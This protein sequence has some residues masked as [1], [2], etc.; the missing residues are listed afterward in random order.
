MEVQ[1]T[2]DL[3]AKVNLINEM[4][5]KLEDVD[6][7]QVDKEIEDQEKAADERYN[8]FDSDMAFRKE[9]LDD[10]IIPA[11]WK[12]NPEKSEK[13]G[14]EITEKQHS[15]RLEKDDKQAKVVMAENKELR[16][17][18]P[19]DIEKSSEEYSRRMETKHDKLR[20]KWAGTD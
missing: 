11:G 10:D 1:S 18:N 2:G 13:S 14:K 16:D 4:E 7:E 5:M 8:N 6:L 12:V 17:T 19:E 20:M 15:N 3:V 9:G